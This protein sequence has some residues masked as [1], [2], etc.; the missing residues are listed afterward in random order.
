M[1]LGLWSEMMDDIVNDDMNFLD[2][3]IKFVL[4]FI[5]NLFSG[6]YRRYYSPSNDVED[7][8]S[9]LRYTEGM[10]RRPLSDSNR[11]R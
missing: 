9:R 4:L 3:K 5:P 1:R 10:T 11:A 7:K 6:F 2:L 8:A